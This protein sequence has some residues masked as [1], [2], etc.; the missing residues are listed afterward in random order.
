MTTYEV[1]RTSLSMAC[2][3]AAM[4]GCR[5]VEM[6]AVHLSCSDAETAR[7]L[8]GVKISQTMYAGDIEVG[9][10]KAVPVKALS[11]LAAS[12]AQPNSVATATVNDAAPQ[13][14]E[15]GKPPAGTTPAAD[16]KAPAAKA[17]AAA[18][19]K[20]SP[21]TTPAAAEKE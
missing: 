1:I 9:Q 3:A 14:A 18:E 5:I 7:A 2:L 10:A 17:E 8:C 19:T 20:P 21:D 11:D 12:L 15:L 4:V 16:D 13:T 6:Q